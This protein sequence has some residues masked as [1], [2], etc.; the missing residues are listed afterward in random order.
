MILI[1]LGP[2]GSGKGTQAKRLTAK[3]NWPQLSTG[4]MF[5]ANIAQKTPMGLAAKKFMDDGQLVPDEVVIGMIKARI[6]DPDCANGFIFDGF[7]RT[8]PQAEA[9]DS[10]LAAK[11]LKVDRAIEFKIDDSELVGRLSGRRTCT[12]CGT[13]Y[14]VITMPTKVDGV[15]DKCGGS[16]V[17]RDDDHESVIAKRLNV[18]HAQTAP[19]VAFYA[20]QGKL[21]TLD[22]IQPM[23]MVF[24]ALQKAI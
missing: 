10:M 19:L 21:K 11:G 7:P 9:L 12:K 1:F 3:K 16:V 24:E 8:I 4:D 17:Q 15:C 20:G 22:A 23:D 5:R 6:E 14:H 18:Y 2:P 13:M